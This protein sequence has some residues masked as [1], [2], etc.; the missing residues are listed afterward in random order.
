MSNYIRHW[1]EDGFDGKNIQKI[2]ITQKIKAP[3]IYRGFY[4]MG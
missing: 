2:E 3:V 1:E 4:F